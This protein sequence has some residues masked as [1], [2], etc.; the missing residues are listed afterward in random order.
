MSTAAPA[1][2][3]NIDFGRCFRVVFD[4][5]DWIKKVLIGGVFVLL[6]GLIVGLFF[7]A[8]YWARLVKSAAA[9]QPRPLPEWD[10]LG[11][12]FGDGLKLV[13]LYFV[14]MLAVGLVVGVV[15]GAGCLALAGLGAA[16]SHSEEAGSVV[17][18]LGGLGFM[19][20]YLVFL[21]VM[22]AL[23]LY[24]P[25]AFVRVVERDD[26]AAGFQWRENFGFIRANLA[27]YALSLVLYLVASFV[28]QFGLLLCCV[29]IFPAAF[30]GY[31]VFGF[32]LGETVRLN[33][34]SV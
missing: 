31:C 12:I 8:G 10:D 21:V 5:P 34:G 16:T 7:V 6:S 24:L 23:G 17:A 2:S 3:T 28:A 14:Y 13:G 22:L 4:D 26:F 27:N 15:G 30:W 20:L 29:G 1:P 9:G 33:P 25:A 11:G 18:A 32:A 19:G